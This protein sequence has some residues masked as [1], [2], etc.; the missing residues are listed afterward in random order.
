MGKEEADPTHSANF[1]VGLQRRCNELG[2]GCE[3]VHPG[4]PDAKHRTTSDHLIH[5]L[6]GK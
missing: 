2:I 1:G 3:F 5:R 4:T 6:T